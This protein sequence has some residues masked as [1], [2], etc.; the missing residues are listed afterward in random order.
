MNALN[1]SVHMYVRIYVLLTG[2]GTGAY[3]CLPDSVVGLIFVVSGC[4]L[5]CY[6]MTMPHLLF[7]VSLYW[8]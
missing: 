3:G 2:C 6:R 7:C 1:I 8:K 4:V 5:A